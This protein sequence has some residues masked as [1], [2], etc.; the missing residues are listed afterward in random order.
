MKINGE[1]VFLRFGCYIF[2]GFGVNHFGKK[3]Q[4]CMIQNLDTFVC[5]NKHVNYT[6]YNVILRIA[7]NLLETRENIKIESHPFLTLSNYID[8]IH[9]VAVAL[10]LRT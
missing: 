3:S 7:R 9:S 8:S 5:T 4:I 10:I 2:V 6:V 1:I